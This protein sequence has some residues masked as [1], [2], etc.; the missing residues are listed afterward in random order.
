MS[1]IAKGRDEAML[2]GKD[3]CSTLGQRGL[4]RSWNSTPNRPAETEKKTWGEDVC[5]GQVA[6]EDCE[7]TAVGVLLQGSLAHRHGHEGQRQ[8]LEV[9]STG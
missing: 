5:R 4:Q 8:R 9:L 3:G 2:T 7:L 1:G 6:T